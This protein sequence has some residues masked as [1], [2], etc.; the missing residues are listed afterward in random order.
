MDVIP[1][2]DVIE[3][4]VEDFS[5][6]E[7]IKDLLGNPELGEEVISDKLF[8]PL[9]ENYLPVKS[10]ALEPLFMFLTLRSLSRIQCLKYL[11]T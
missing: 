9:S 1:D 5:Y 7:N 11:L 2:Q 3:E 10:I 4:M 8:S 6:S